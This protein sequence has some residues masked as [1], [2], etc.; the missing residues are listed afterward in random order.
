MEQYDL[1]EMAALESP[2]PSESK[3]IQVN[4]SESKW[5]QMN[6]SE[7]KWKFLY[8]LTSLY[9]CTVSPRTPSNKHIF[10]MIKIQNF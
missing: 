10:Y 2:T 4:P 6:A 1:E 9:E 5:I 7:S 3:W 8:R